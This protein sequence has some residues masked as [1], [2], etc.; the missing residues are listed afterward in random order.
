MKFTLK[1]F[2][3]A[4]ACTVVAAGIAS[5][6]NPANA[7]ENKDIKIGVSIWSSTDVP[8]TVSKEMVKV[9][10]RLILKVYN[11]V[12]PLFAVTTT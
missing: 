12:A 6:S 9:G 11:C 2:A 1:K 3:K 7:I 8:P 5:F 10:R 4:I